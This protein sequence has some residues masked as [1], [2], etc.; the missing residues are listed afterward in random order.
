MIIQLFKHSLV[1][2]TGFIAHVV[3]RTLSSDSLL[4]FECSLHKS[5]VTNSISI[6]RNLVSVVQIHMCGKMNVRS[7]LI[8]ISISTF[9][10]SDVFQIIH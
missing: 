9:Q 1:F 3:T 7:Y 8:I 6:N 5:N 4:K 10:N 2:Q